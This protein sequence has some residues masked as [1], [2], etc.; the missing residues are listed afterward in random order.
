MCLLGALLW[1]KNSVDV[2][3]NTSRSDGYTSKEL[4]QLFIILY[5]KSDVPWNDTALLVITGCVS[6]KLQNFSAEVLKYSCKV[7]WSSSSDTSSILSFTEV[8]AD[9]TYW[10]LKSSLC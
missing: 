10:K 8:T 9:T 2:W 7:N 6:S 5:S 4:V 3:K 1:Q